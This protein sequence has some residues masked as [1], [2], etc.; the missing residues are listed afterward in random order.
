M[1][2][3]HKKA[4][5]WLSAPP[6]DSQRPPNPQW[7]LLSTIS[8]VRPCVVAACSLSEF[9]ENFLSFFHFERI[10][11]THFFGIWYFPYFSGVGGMGM[12]QTRHWVKQ[13]PMHSTHLLSQPNTTV[14]TNTLHCQPEPT[15]QHLWHPLLPLT[16]ANH[17]WCY[18]PPPSDTTL[19]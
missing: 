9:D 5:I 15:T 12:G 6:T 1:Q 8:S 4:Q 17:H 16:T 3:W 11:S 19:A 14:A 10:N 2:I 18:P 7:V 13:H